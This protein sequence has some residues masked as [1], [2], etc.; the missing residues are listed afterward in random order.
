MRDALWVWTGRVMACDTEAQLQALQ[1]RAF[2]DL[3]DPL[4]SDVVTL[5]YQRRHRL[6]LE[7]LE[8][9]PPP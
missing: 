1:A 8:A 3:E 9:R 4:L 2:R 5:I 6:H 7:A